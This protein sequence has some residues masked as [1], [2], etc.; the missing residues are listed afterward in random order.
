[1]MWILANIRMV[2]FAALV[3]CIPIAYIIGSY[4]GKAKCETKQQVKQLEHT[5]KVKKSHEK[6]DRKTPYAA[7][8]STRLEWM[9]NNIYQ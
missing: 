1:M 7:D 4:G 8:R 6:I 2:G 9:R 3:A 5:V